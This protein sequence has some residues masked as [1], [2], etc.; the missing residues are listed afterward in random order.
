M[1]RIVPAHGTSPTPLSCPADPRP[2]DVSL[3]SEHDSRKYAFTYTTNEQDRRERAVVLSQIVEYPRH[4]HAV[5]S[6]HDQ[7]EAYTHRVRAVDE[8]WYGIRSEM[9]ALGSR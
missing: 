6:L 7:Y 2:D 8:Y 5:F 4:L 1:L 3:M 9:Q